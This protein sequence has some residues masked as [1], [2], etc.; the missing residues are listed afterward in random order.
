MISN[1]SIVEESKRRIYDAIESLMASSCK[2]TQD[3]VE[4]ISGM[5]IATVKKYWI[6]FKDV[7]KIHNKELSGKQKYSSN[8]LT[9]NLN[10]EEILP[11]ESILYEVVPNQ[12]IIAEERTDFIE[13]QNVEKIDMD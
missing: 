6:E 5:S 1:W 12:K 4:K 3:R 11:V 2:I 8:Y 10:N 9:E 7:V 13:I